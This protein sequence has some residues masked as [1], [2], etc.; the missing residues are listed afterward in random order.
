MNGKVNINIK[1]LKIK[2]QFIM[3]SRFQLF[4]HPC[5][6]CFTKTSH[7]DLKYKQYSTFLTFMQF[8]P[9]KINAMD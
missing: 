9:P 8:Y 6:D 2:I 7:L 3:F 5:V 1:M 4:S